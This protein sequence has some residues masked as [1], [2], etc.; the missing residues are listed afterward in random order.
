ME[1]YQSSHCFE[2]NA[3]ILAPTGDFAVLIKSGM[4]FRSAVIVNFAEAM[5]AYIGL[6]SGLTVSTIDHM[7]EW[8]FSLTAG[9]FLYIALVDLVSNH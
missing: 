6:L 8:I 3:Y 4:S 1:N 7:K 9:I 2:S 5:P